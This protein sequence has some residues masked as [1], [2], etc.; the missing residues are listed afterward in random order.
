MS[1]F[2]GIQI[3][4][5]TD[6]HAKEMASK[7]LKGKIIA[8]RNI[9]V[10]DCYK[11]AADIIQKPSVTGTTK[12]RAVPHDFMPVVAGTKVISEQKVQR[13]GLLQNAPTRHNVKQ[14]QL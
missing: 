5:Y 11:I 6:R 14:R 4:Y 13:S 1:S 10:N 9:S 12:R 3:N 8:P 7:I 2:T